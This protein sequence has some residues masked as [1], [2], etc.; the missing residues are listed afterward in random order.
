MRI[1]LT[2]ALLS[3]ASFVMQADTLTAATAAAP[4][5]IVGR[6]VDANGDA[7]AD[8]K[9]QIEMTHRSGRT[10]KLNTSTDRR[11]HFRFDRVP[12][13]RGVIRAGKHG[14]GRDRERVGVRSGQTT[15]VGLELH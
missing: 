12:A 13:S 7:V 14:V 5:Q 2:L 15:R 9:V 3:S 10:F 8:A 4:G 1:L 11:G 6:V